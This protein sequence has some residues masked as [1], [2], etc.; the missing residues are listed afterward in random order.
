[1]TACEWLVL[2]LKSPLITA[3]VTVLLSGCVLN[4]S[5]EK[6]K[7]RL[8]ANQAIIQ[9]R[10]EIYSLIKDDLNNIYSY[11]K[12]VGKWKNFSPDQILGFKR[13]A[14][15][16]MHSNKP[17]WSESMQLEYDNFM[18]TCF[19]TNR[20]HTLDAGIIANVEKYKKVPTWEDDFDTYFTGEFDEEKLDEAY[21][22]LLLALSKDLGV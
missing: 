7:S 9:K 15:L 6:L 16:E 19:S 11:I 5:L 2:V 3:I 8:Q 18:R 4:R 17:F 14:D 1:M 13:N 22:K 12:R 10:I 20:E 21:K